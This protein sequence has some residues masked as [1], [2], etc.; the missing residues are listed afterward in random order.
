MLKL[1]PITATVFSVII[2]A[3]PA[4]HAGGMTQSSVSEK[5]PQTQAPKDTPQ[6]ETSLPHTQRDL[7][8]TKARADQMCVGEANQCFYK[9]TVNEVVDQMQLRVTYP[10]SVWEETMESERTTPK[11]TAYRT[12]LE[13]LQFQIS[14]MAPNAAEVG[15]T[16]VF[17]RCPEKEFTLGPMIDPN[18]IG[19]PV[20]LRQSAH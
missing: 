15:K 12:R 6:G 2:L 3:C 10:P 20:D 17:T 4:G 13:T 14:L 9:F 8:C 16:Y 7:D 18:Q 5:N 19:E 11:E 1:S